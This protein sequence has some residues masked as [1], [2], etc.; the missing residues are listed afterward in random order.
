[1][2]SF[3]EN[4]QFNEIKNILEEF[5]FKFHKSK[6]TFVFLGQRSD[7]NFNTKRN[8]GDQRCLKILFN[9]ESIAHEVKISKVLKTLWEVCTFLIIQKI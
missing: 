1:M 5:K 2:I 3:I 4:Y 9:D 7:K 6:K 8:A